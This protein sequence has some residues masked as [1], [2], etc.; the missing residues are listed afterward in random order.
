M[1][2]QNKINICDSRLNF[3]LNIWIF[4]QSY[5]VV[6]KQCHLFIFYELNSFLM[7]FKLMVHIVSNIAKHYSQNKFC[8]LPA[9][10][11]PGFS[12]SNQSAGEVDLK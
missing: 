9:A 5:Q 8:L 11:F 7:V 12:F 10:T 1:H 4:K 3:C 2:I 6:G